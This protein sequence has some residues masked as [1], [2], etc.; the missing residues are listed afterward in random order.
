MPLVRLHGHAGA[1]KTFHEDHINP[2]SPTVIT[3]VS[4]FTLLP[5]LWLGAPAGT[6]TSPG[7][8]V[9]LGRFVASKSKRQ[10]VRSQHSRSL[11]S[12]GMSTCEKEKEASSWRP[13]KREAHTPGGES[14]WNEEAS[15]ALP[16]PFF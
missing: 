6:T 2:P 16:P 11:A 15:R 1:V 10:S 8:A 4:L 14:R 9:V 13:G 12:A 7:M 5:A 3:R